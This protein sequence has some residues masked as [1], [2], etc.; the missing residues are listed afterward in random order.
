MTQPDDPEFLAWAKRL[1]TPITRQTP[2]GDIRELT[3]RYDYETRE[4]RRGRQEA[5][6]RR[7]REVRKLLSP[8]IPQS[9]PSMK[10]DPLRKRVRAGW[11]RGTSSTVGEAEADASRG[12][13]L[14]RWLSASHGADSEQ[15]RLA[16]MRHYLSRRYDLGDPE[17]LL[18]EVVRA[19]RAFQ[20]ERTRRADEMTTAMRPSQQ[21]EDLKR[22][23]RRQSMNP[24]DN[25]EPGIAHYNLATAPGR[26]NW[27]DRDVKNIS[28]D[29]DLET[30]ID[31]T[32]GQ[33]LKFPARSL[34]FSGKYSSSVIQSFARV[35]KA[36]NRLVPFVI[37][38]PDVDIYAD[39]PDIDTL[40]P[41]ERS[42]MAVPYMLTPAVQ[43][44]HAQDPLL[45]VAAGLLNVLKLMAIQK[46]LPSG[47]PLGASAI[48]TTYQIVS[49]GAG[50][51][52]AAFDEVV[53]ATTTF[54][55][56]PTAAAQIAR[57]ASAFYLQN[58]VAI[59]LGALTSTQLT[60]EIFGQESGLFNVGDE[61]TIAV[62]AEEEAARTGVG[63]WK[64]IRAEIS[65]IDE[66]GRLLV[67]VRSVDSISE[68][69]AQSEYDLGKKVIR[70]ALKV[71]STSVPTSVPRADAGAAMRETGKTL[72]RTLDEYPTI[73]RSDQKLMAR[74][75]KI[76][77]LAKSDPHEA[78]R[79][80]KALDRE[81]ER[82]QGMSTA[83]MATDTPSAAE[84][85][86]EVGEWT[87]I[88]KPPGRV[89]LEPKIKG[90]LGEATHQAEVVQGAVRPISKVLSP[91]T[92]QDACEALIQR[93]ISLRDFVALLPK[94]GA[95]QLRLPTTL[96]GYRI[97]DHVYLEGEKVVFRESKNY[98]GN[99]FSL[100]D[101]TLLQLD[102]DLGY[103]AAFKSE[104][105]I[106]WRI[107]ANGLDADTAK[108]L[109]DLVLKHKEEFSYV[110]RP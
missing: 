109:D 39:L 79:L 101:Q 57:S 66:S 56:T 91:Q 93:N 26:P 15:E 13:P 85:Q 62:H 60:F 12:V 76:A 3:A 84:Q 8:S 53:S 83:G 97:I 34:D 74:W 5:M 94:E 73:L 55:F 110:V 52:R 38:R 45:T 99:I 17:R 18:D 2:Y 72:S 48:R 10:E 51:G 58:A 108:K 19:E 50:I 87:V 21:L 29:H 95:S 98:A 69:A 80:A 33:S 63:T 42:L 6:R 14:E 44:F 40:S 67:R 64:A 104:L 46:A 32:T 90:D 102:K 107:T 27:V 86:A 71:A 20:D 24:V 59:N 31:Y 105:R 28:Q 68:G 9:A 75:R 81:L 36:S 37:Y 30:R 106:E 47:S 43:A 100:T 22:W 103:L 1:G 65:E 82:R 89:N 11:S 96:G 7:H 25:F 54:G 88:D 78:S 23:L 16:Y 35:H 92:L 41:L 61:L 49:E 70:K 77:R 4:E